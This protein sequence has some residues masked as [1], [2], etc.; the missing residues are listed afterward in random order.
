MIT[1]YVICWNEK[2]L[3][4]FMH[5]FYKSRFPDAKFV[6][7]DNESDDGSP[8]IARRLG[9]EVV[10]YQTY[11]KL[12]D[13]AYTNIRN[14][15]WKTASTDWVIVCDM[16]ELYDIWPFQLEAESRSGATICRAVGYNMVNME[17]NYDLYSIKHG[18]RA[19]QYDKN[20]C[21]NRKYIRET[22]FDHGAHSAKPEG[23]IKYSLNEYRA[24]HFKYIHPQYLVERYKAFAQRMSEENRQHS[25]GF[26]YLRSEAEILGEFEGAR[27]MSFKLL[28]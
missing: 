17:D 1:I 26:H 13:S 4:P 2:L 22:N 3:L 7:Y 5:Q 16:D 9:C 25:W 10:T 23:V 15:C 12:S 21:F 20:Y 11:G 8:D 27:K 14:N 28:D 24:Y 18:S 6:I 19:K